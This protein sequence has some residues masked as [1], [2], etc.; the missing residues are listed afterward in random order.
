MTHYN[1]I[2][3]FAGACLRPIRLARGETDPSTPFTDSPCDRHLAADAFGMICSLGPFNPMIE[4]RNGVEI[5][6]VP[7]P[8]SRERLAKK[9]ETL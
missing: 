8:S 7:W 2:A 4:S 9:T 1:V 3:G 5:L 6:E